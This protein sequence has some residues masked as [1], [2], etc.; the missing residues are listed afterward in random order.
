MQVIFLFKKVCL[1][2]CFILIIPNIAYAKE[3]EI[4]ANSAIVIDAYTKTT[5][6]EKNAYEKRAVASTTKIMTCLIACES[7]ELNEIITVSSEMLEG[8]EGS[9]IYLEAGDKISLYDLVCGAIIASGNDAANAIAFHI[10]GSIKNFALLMNEKAK[11]IGMTST[12]FVTPS[13]LDKGGNHSTA[14]DMALLAENALNNDELL[15]IASMKSAK[16]SINGKEQTIFNHNKLL[17]YSDSFIGLKTGYTNKAGRCLVSAYR[18]SDNI[19]ICVTLGAPD[20]WDDHKTLVNYAKKC[21]KDINQSQKIKI[22][23]VGSEKEQVICS[24]NYSVKALNGIS[25]KRYFYPFVYAPVAKGECI[26]REEVFI[27][28]KL[29][30]TAEITA[31]EDIKR[32]QI[33]K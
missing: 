23:V 31:N 16:I 33:T 11:A 28:N 26:G 30:K 25:V 12:K 14:Y 15:K 7:G 9:L 32:W 22:N 24:V 8:C 29:I 5:L 10:S 19:I 2:L 18:Y 13:G 3:F 4:S 1:L 20:D 21:Y 6:F 17:S 27:N